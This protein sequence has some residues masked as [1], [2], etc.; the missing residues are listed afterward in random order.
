MRKFYAVLA[1][2]LIANVTTSYLWYAL[3][4]WLYLETKSVLATALVGGVYM[5]LI[6]FLDLID[7]IRVKN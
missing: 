6:A 5:L 2:T 1:N 4:F 7:K 3:T